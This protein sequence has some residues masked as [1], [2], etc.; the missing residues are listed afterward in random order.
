MPLGHISNKN[1]AAAKVSAAAGKSVAAEDFKRKTGD[2][3]RS[4]FSQEDV[5]ELKRQDLLVGM[6]YR[7]PGDEE[8]PKP[9]K[10]WRVI[11]FSFLFRGLSLPAHEFLRGLLF[12]YGLQLYHLTPNSLLHIAVFITFC[13]CYL[14]IYPHWG[15]W[16]TLYQVRGQSGDGGERY[17]IGGCGFSIRS[18]AKFL[19]NAGVDSI[20]N[21]R[22]KWFYVK[23]V[24]VEGQAENLA[25]FVD[26]KADNLSSWQNKLTR[27]EKLEVKKL[28]PRVEEAVSALEQEYG[29]VRLVSIFIGRRLQPLQARSIPMWEYSGPSDASRVGRK[30]FETTED[31]EMAIKSIIKGKKSKKLPTP[32]SIAPF[33]SENKL[34]EVFSRLVLAFPFDRSIL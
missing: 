4:T 11:F 34:P 25:A 23:D 17:T 28:M 18:S 6:E 24:P 16:K 13:E 3:A 27:K 1:T 20:Q 8:I 31:L 19:E 29:F 21:W 32:C 30:D 15:L 9:P 12:V 26:V 7:I 2:W 22:D 5:D 14:G 10:G 33:G